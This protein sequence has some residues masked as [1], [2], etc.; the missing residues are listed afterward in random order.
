MVRLIE[1]FVKISAIMWSYISTEEALRGLFYY[2]GMPNRK[3]IS[4]MSLYDIKDRIFL[5]FRK[6]LLRTLFL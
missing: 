4:F 6:N 2:G 3:R 5:V 1:Y